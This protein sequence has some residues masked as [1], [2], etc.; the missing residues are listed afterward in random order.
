MS[1]GKRIG[2]DVGGSHV[3]ACLI[4]PAKEGNEYLNFL[5]K[6][7][8]SRSSAYSI[9]TAISDCIKET[10]AGKT[11][12]A[13]IGLAFPGPFNYSKGVSAITGVGGKFEKT[14]G[15]HVESALKDGTGIQAS[16]SFANDAHCF[17]VG[18]YKRY[19]LK[20]KRTVFLTLGTGFGSAF[21]QD[22][23]L[24]IHHSSIQIGRA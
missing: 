21:V 16:V 23:D 20:S 11:D 8:D 17:A 24:L 1:T 9:I 19:S 4:D 12:I 10:A 3:S 13:S 15:L 5:R 14:F 7:I 18:A 22:S 6:E 2:V